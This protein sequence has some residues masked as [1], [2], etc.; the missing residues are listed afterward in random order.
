MIDDRAM[1][2]LGIEE[3]DV[4]TIMNEIQGSVG[5]IEGELGSA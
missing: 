4:K 1:K 2:F 5:M 3:T